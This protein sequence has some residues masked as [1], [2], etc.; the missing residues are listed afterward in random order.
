[1]PRDG[2][3]G[4]AGRNSKVPAAFLLYYEVLNLLTLDWSPEQ[5]EDAACPLMLAGTV[6][7][8]QH[9]NWTSLGL[10]Q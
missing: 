5:L 3:V 10:E 7:A 4:G 9:S 6:G 1:M 8:H 2:E